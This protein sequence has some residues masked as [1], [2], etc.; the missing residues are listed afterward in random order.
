MLWLSDMHVCQV[1]YVFAHYFG[2]ILL[3]CSGVL[4]QGIGCRNIIPYIRKYGKHP[5]TGAHLK[6][7][8]LI[9]L[10]FHKNPEGKFSY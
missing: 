3:W 7:E 6:Q 8:D 9:P 10:T 2:I 5:V 4:H 1:L